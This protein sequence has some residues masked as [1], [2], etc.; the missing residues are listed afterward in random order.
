MPS[1][2]DERDEDYFIEYIL[3]IVEKILHIKD[4]IVL[5]SYPIL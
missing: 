5:Y 2:L 1:I 4:F 3:H